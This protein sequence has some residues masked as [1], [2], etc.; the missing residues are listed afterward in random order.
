MS[1]RKMSEYQA[2]MLLASKWDRTQR[3]GNACPSVAIDGIIYFGL[4]EC[5]Y[6]SDPGSALTFNMLN[7]IAMFAPKPTV[8]GYRWPRTAKGARGRAAFCRRMAR[9]CKA[10]KK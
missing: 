3:N 8:T 1:K 6:Y 7:K 2:W 9:M 10:G 5:I 4:C